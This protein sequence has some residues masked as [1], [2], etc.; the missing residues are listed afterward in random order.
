MPLTGIY[1]LESHRESDKIL[2]ELASIFI[3]NGEWVQYTSSSRH[4]IEF[5]SALELAR[6]KDQDSNWEEES[7]KIVVVDACTPHFGF[8]DSIYRVRT[9]DAKKMCLDVIQSSPS[10]AGIHTAAARAFN[11]I[12]KHSNNTRAPTLVIY[13][14]LHGLVDLESDEQYR[15]FYRHVLPSER[16]WGGMFTVVVEF[17][18]SEAN[19]GHI[20]TYGDYFW[21]SLE[22]SSP[23]NSD[24]SEKT[25]SPSYLPNKTEALK[26]NE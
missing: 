3:K 16:L 26:D 20:R 24:G 13:E 14:G 19:L 25:K 10:F 23:I 22:I 5:L 9:D 21:K 6:K 7:K 17:S 8:T 11:I 4:P 12:K 1:Q 18:P 2:V 15:V